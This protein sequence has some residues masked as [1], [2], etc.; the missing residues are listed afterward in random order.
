M[1]LEGS[2]SCHRAP[3]V[4]TGRRVLPC[5]S[6]IQL[7]SLRKGTRWGPQQVPNVCLDVKLVGAKPAALTVGAATRAGKDLS[8]GTENPA[9]GIPAWEGKPS[10][11]E[12]VPIQLHPITFQTGAQTVKG[13]PAAKG[14]AACPRMG[15]IAPTQKDTKR[16]S[17][18]SRGTPDQYPAIWLERRRSQIGCW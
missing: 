2:T 15:N 16:S 13:S 18:S 14:I 4:L 12:E 7:W 5:Q 11:E 9:P 3:K 1:E 10:W 8:K 17:S 6:K